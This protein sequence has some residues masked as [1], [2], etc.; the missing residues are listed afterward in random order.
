MHPREA[1]PHLLRGAE[2]PRRRTTGGTGMVMPDSRAKGTSTPIPLEGNQAVNTPRRNPEPLGIVLVHGAAVVVEQHAL[3]FLGPSGAGKSTISKLLEPF[4]PVIGDDKLYLIPEGSAWHVADA[5]TRA[6]KGALTEKEARRLT[7]APL[8][9]VFRLFQSQEIHVTQ[10]DAIQ[11]CRYLL[12]GFY[13]LYFWS[14]HIGL[15]A[16]RAVF[17]SVADIARQTPGF[18]LHFHKSREIVNTIR[19]TISYQVHKSGIQ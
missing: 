4:A 7:S 9:A 18:D 15:E 13:E 5:T 14:C 11:T 8:G 17:S 1:L 2:L 6:S 10:V 3:I 12:I 16:Q 19:G